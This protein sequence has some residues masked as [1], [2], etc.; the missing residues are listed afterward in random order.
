MLFLRSALPCDVVRHGNQTWL[1]PAKKIGGWK[2]PISAVYG[3]L[4]V[5]F[6]VSNPIESRLLIEPFEESVTGDDGSPLNDLELGEIVLTHQLVG[7]GTGDTEKACHFHYGEEHGK[8]ISA[9][10]HRLLH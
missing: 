7:T 4:T 3:S 8:L 5:A 10:I 1:Y 6:T 9:L 2:A